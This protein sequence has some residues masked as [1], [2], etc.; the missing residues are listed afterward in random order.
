MIKFLIKVKMA[1][2]KF[3]FYTPFCAL[4]SCENAPQSLH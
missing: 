4:S 2:L 3:S 1:Y